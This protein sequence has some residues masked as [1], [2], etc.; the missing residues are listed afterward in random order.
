LKKSGGSRFSIKQAEKTQKL[1]INKLNRVKEQL[2]KRQDD[3]VHFEEL[4]LD[5]LVLDEAHEFKNLYTHTKLQNVAG[6]STNDNVQKTA[7]L[8]AKCRYLDEETGGRGTIFAT[9]TPVSNSV[10]ELHRAY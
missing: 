1:L 4:G 8:F 10:T 7:D 6:I 5:K 2:S 9:G 3:V